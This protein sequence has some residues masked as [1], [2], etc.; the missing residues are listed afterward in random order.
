MTD[1]QDSIWRT[2]KAKKAEAAGAK[3][4][5]QAESSY[6]VFCGSKTDKS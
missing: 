6:P 3:E 4:T 5:L 2:T 1:A